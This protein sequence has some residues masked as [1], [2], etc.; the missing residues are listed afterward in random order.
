M[1]KQRWRKEEAK[2]F[3]SSH[4]ATRWCRLERKV[5][6]KEAEGSTDAT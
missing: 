1:E 6:G 2:T 5:D 3:L 4:T